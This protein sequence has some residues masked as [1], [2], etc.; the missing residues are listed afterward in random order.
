MHHAITDGWSLDILFRELEA[1][2]RALASGG[3]TPAFTSL[4]VQYADYAQ[5]QRRWMRGDVLEKE[6]ACWREK[7]AG[8]PQSLD[9]PADFAPSG[10][11]AQKA[12]RHDNRFCRR[13]FAMKF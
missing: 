1:G 3:A 6:L 9:L 5:W 7:L 11:P 12:A 10:K 4:Q 8:A 13:R 2:Y